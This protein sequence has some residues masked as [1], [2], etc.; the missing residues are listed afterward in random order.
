[1]VLGNIFQNELIPGNASLVGRA[2]LVDKYNI[3]AY[4]RFPSCVSREHVR[5]AS[6]SRDGWRLYDKRYWPGDRDIDHIVFALKYELF[7]LLVLKRILLAIP[8]QEV[9]EYILSKPTGIYARKICFLY[10]WLLE[11]TIDLPDCPKCQ[12]KPL[13]NPDKYFTVD[14]IYLSCYT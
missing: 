4:V 6:V 12:T 9:V 10:E 2:F 11:T 3:S 8:R 13:L 7:D 5:G 14:G 1:M